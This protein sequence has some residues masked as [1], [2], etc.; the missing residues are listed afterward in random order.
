MYQLHF[1]CYYSSIEGCVNAKLIKKCFNDR[2]SFIWVA[3][4]Q[5]DIPMSQI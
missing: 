5:E 4:S 2:F 3:F 1:D